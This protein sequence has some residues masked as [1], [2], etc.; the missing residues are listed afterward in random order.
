MDGATQRMPK[1][2]DILL[3]DDDP[4]DV[5]LTRKALSNGKIY[6]KLHVAEDGIEALSFL[7]REGKFADAPRPELILLD[8]NMPRKDG[9]ETLAEIKADENLRGIPVVILTTSDADQDVAKSYNLQASCYITKPVDL[10]QFT[11]V[12]QSINNFWLCVVT[13][14][15]R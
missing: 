8:L 6:N 13:F 12:V 1:L 3:V 7:R 2:I 10:E 14:P 5:L 4:G 15:E 9:R 11:K